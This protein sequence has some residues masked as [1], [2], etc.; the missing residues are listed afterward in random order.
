[1]DPGSTYEMLKPG[2]YTLC[3]SAGSRQGTPAIALPLEGGRNRR[4]PVGTVTVER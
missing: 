4:Y 2:T 1:M 3:V